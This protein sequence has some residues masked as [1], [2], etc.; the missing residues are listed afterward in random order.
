MLIWDIFDTIKRPVSPHP[1]TYAGMPEDLDDWT[2]YNFINYY[3]ANRVIVGPDRAKRYVLED[4][5]K[6]HMFA[7]LYDDSYDCYVL[8]YWQDTFDQMFPGT[9]APIGTAWCSGKE[10]VSTGAKVVTGVTT[11]AKVLTS[12][13]FLIP[14]GIAVVAFFAWPYIKPTLKK[15]KRG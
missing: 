6:I 5:D 7:T 8:K 3:E 2:G 11:T 15:R 14:A 12:P 10:V 9:D 13:A 1:E 4:I